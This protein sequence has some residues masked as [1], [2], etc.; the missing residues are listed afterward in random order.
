MNS[1]VFCELINMSFPIKR[2]EKIR[3]PAKPFNSEHSVVVAVDVGNEFTKAAYWNGEDD[4][5]NTVSI[6][7]YNSIPTAIAYLVRILCMN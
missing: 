6:D 4:C 1:I 5:S 2:T 3:V 7:G